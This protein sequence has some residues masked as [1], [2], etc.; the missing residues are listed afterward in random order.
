MEIPFVPPP[1]HDQLVLLPCPSGSSPQALPLSHSPFDN[2]PVFPPPPRRPLAST[3]TVRSSKGDDCHCISTSL[4]HS[5]TTAPPLRPRTRGFPWY[6][7]ATLIPRGVSSLGSGAQRDSSE[8]STSL[9]NRVPGG[10]RDDYSYKDWRAMMQAEIRKATSSSTTAALTRGRCRRVIIFAFIPS[11]HRGAP[12]ADTELD[13]SSF[14]LVRQ[15]KTANS[16]GECLKLGLFPLLLR[17]SASFKASFNPSPHASHLTSLDPP[18]PSSDDVWTPGWTRRYPRI[19]Q[20]VAFSS[21]RSRR[22]IWHA[23]HGRSSPSF[24][25]H[26]SLGALFPLD[27]GLDGLDGN[28]SRLQVG[29]MLRAWLANFA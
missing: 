19:G 29:P 24:G 3:S 22:P 8:R 6:P 17:P 4:L 16:K 5:S 23:A 11:R 14:P 15:R 27:E 10:H 9:S 7:S 13:A 28:S 25:G 12:G 18:F 21:L 2:N 20:T 1:P 26:P